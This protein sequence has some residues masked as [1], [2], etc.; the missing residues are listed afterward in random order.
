VADEEPEHV[1][2]CGRQ[3]SDET[4]GLVCA[5]NTYHW[6][7]ISAETG[8]AFPAWTEALYLEHL[9]VIDPDGAD[10]IRAAHEAGEEIPWQ[11]P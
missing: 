11:L 3:L 4:Y 5:K 1:W 9:D 2:Y 10:E 6:G 8:L 7:E